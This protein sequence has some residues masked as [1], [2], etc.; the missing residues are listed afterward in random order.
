MFT[1]W[2]VWWRSMQLQV[3]ERISSKIGMKRKRDDGVL[4]Q[5][6]LTS[7]STSVEHISCHRNHKIKRSS[8]KT[9]FHCIVEEISITTILHFVF[10]IKTHVANRLKCLLNDLNVSQKRC[11]IELANEDWI[12]SANRV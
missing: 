5:D 8:S 3:P 10:R 12:P 6:R 11:K 1:Q 2:L 7:S 4:T 9:H